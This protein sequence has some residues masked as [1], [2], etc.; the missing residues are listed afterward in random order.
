MNRWL[1]R[2]D[3]GHQFVCQINGLFDEERKTRLPAQCCGLPADQIW[4]CEQ[5]APPGHACQVDDHTI[6]HERMGNGYTCSAVE[7]W[8]AERGGLSGWIRASSA[9][10]VAVGP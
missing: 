2:P 6:L 10:Y 1:F 5:I 9:R 4:K 3:P 7:I 8:L